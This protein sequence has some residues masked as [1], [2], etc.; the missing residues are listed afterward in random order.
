MMNAS[1]T[2]RPILVSRVMTTPMGESDFFD[3]AELGRSGAGVGGDFSVGGGDGLLR[4]NPKLPGLLR[5]PKRLLGAAILAR[6][7]TDHTESPATSQMLRPRTQQRVEVVQLV[8][9]SYA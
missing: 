7:E 5:R 6:V 3:H 9:H 2:S 8:V 1:P 4:H